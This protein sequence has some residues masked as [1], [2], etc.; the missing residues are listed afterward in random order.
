VE[1]LLWI[2]IFPLKN[3]FFIHKVDK[4]NKTGSK[5]L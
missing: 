1:K 4:T 3:V 2:F 5:M